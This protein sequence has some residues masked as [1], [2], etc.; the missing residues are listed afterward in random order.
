[1]LG[2][3]QAATAKE[4]PAMMIVLLWLLGPPLSLI[5]ILL[6]LGGH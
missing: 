4:R 2:W 3:G 5:L 1:M 6:L